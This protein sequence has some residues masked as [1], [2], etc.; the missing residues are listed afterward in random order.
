MF[1]FYFSYSYIYW[2]RPSGPPPTP[3]EGF[4]RIWVQT[5]GGK[6]EILSAKPAHPTSKTPVV[7]AHGGMGCAWMWTPYMRYLS[8]RGV[9]CYAIS[10]RGHGNSWH[11]SFLRMV[12]TVTKRDLGDDLIAGIKAVRDREG[13]EVVLVGH[14]GGGGLSQFLLHEGDI[15]VK[16]LALLSAIPGNGSWQVFFNWARF[17]PWFTIRTLFHGW[18]SNSPLSHPFLTRQAFFSKDY[19]E[20]ELLEF[21]RHLSRYESIRWPLGMTRPFVDAKKLLQNI[22]GWGASDRLLIMA[23]TA[24]KLM[25]KNVQEQAADTYRIAFSELVKDKQLQAEDEEVRPLAGKGGMD[26]SGHGVRLAWV[27]G[28][29]H[30]LQNEVMWEI[31]AEKILAFLQQL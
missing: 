13:S 28:A 31:G 4:E 11:P 16:G 15:K 6:I 14:S 1:N 18:H 29:G 7:F 2:R 10:T 5:P 3:P 22:T 20:V 27:P 21:Q 17:D 25:T 30:H 9:S 8:E 24:D 12:Y 19:P 23:G 26:N